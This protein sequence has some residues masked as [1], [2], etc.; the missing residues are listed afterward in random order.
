MNHGIFTGEYKVGI[1]GGGQL[2]QMMIQAG[3]SYNISFHILDPSA[4]AP[5][6]N[7]CSEFVQGDFNDFDTV[8]NFGQNVDLLTI[9]IEHVNVDALEKLETEGKAVY[10]SPKLIKTVQDKGAQKAFYDQHGIPTAPYHIIDNRADIKE[11]LDFLP[12]AQKLRTGGYDGKGVTLIDQSNFI[13]NSFDAPSVLEQKVDIDKELSFIVA[14]NVDGETKVF[15]AVELVFNPVYNLVELLFSPAAI[16]PE[17]EKEGEAIAM[18]LANE[19]E[20]VGLLAVEM[21]LDKKG[22][23]LVNEIAPRP[24]NSGHQTIEGNLTSQFEQH[25]RAIL[26]MPLGATNTVE[27]SVMVNLLGAEGYIGS[28]KYEGMEDLLS[29]VG[30][31]PHLY[32]KAITKPGRKMGHVTIVDPSLKRALAT[33]E[34]VKNSIRVVS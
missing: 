21:F 24:H 31:Y 8:Y 17:L 12:A 13:D 22:N 16:S 33:A 23:L 19:L 6:R 11:F 29:E 18:K 7:L 3:I 5:C 30:V 4:E 34:K 26:N 27:P 25:L 15:P 28:A 10:P 20:L 14:R 2:G 32:G 1:L 9:E